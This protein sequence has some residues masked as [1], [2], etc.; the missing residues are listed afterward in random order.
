MNEKVSILNCHVDLCGVEDAL[1]RV[2]SAV[3]ENLNFQIVTINP[4]MIINAQKNKK[5]FDEELV[6]LYT[7][8]LVLAIIHIHEKDA[9]YRDLKPENILLD[10]DGHIKL[11]DFGLCKIIKDDDKAYTI[12]GTITYLAPEILLNKGYQKEVDW[13]S[14]G[15]V[16]YEMLVG[17]APFRIPKG[18]YLSADLYKKKITIPEYVTPEAKDLI[19]QLLVPNPKKRLGYGVDGSK[20]IKDHIYFKGV[21]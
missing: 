1:E 3:N 18:S 5:F 7:M 9:V 14:L 21:N 15:C 17:K 11:T 19:S 12:C 20:K 16:M 10:K 2:L 8:E 6:K 13:W 4:E